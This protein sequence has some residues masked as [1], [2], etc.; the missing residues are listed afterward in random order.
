MPFLG[1]WRVVLR[2]ALVGSLGLAIGVSVV[3]AQTTSASVSGTVKD[4]QGGVLPGATVTLVSHS[5]GNILNSLTDAEGR[6]VFPLVRPDSYTLRV[7]MQGFKTVER[8]NLVVN[9]NVLYALGRYRR[10]F[11]RTH[12]TNNTM[13][14]WMRSIGPHFAARRRGRRPTRTHRIQSSAS[15][16]PV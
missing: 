3:H 2:T 1:Q 9:A 15:A 7:T 6:F 16:R 12:P 14:R 10:L 4:A 11:G 5:Q 13:I 8:T